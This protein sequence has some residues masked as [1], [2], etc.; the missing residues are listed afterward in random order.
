MTMDPQMFLSETRP[1]PERFEPV[2]N[3]DRPIS[4][5]QK[6][7]H[8]GLWTSTIREDGS[9]AWLEWCRATDWGISEATRKWALYPSEDIDVY[10]INA[11]TNLAALLNGFGI[12]DTLGRTALDFEA[13]A[14]TYDALQLTELGERQTRFSEP[15]LYGWDSE[16]TLWF[17]WAFDEVEDLGPVED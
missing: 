13:I 5:L 9:S 15:H 11:Q 6:P 14:S 2:E 7:G 12:P 1:S 4:A 16:S 17:R 8:G 10:T 3:R